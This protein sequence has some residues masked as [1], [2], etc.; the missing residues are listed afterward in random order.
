[1]SD[2]LKLISTIDDLH[3]YLIQA[4]MIEHATLPPYLTA[5]YSLNP[6]ANLDA[7]QILRTVAVE[8]MLH[9]TLAANVF[10]AVGGNIS[11]VLTDPGFVP[12]YPT[13]LPT[14]ADDFQVDR[15]SPNFPERL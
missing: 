2:S 12:S 4:L 14:G 7:Y 11:G 6:G 9:L 15:I 1:M 3:Y 13:F 8:E 5:L 10:N